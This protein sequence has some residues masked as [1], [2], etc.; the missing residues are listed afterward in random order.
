MSNKELRKMDKE[1]KAWDLLVSIKTVMTLLFLRAV[2][3]L[4]KMLFEIG[5]GSSSS[6]GCYFCLT[7]DMK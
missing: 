2:G 7:A 3:E 5:I 6:T 4:E 1:I